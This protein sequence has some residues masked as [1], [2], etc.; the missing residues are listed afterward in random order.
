MTLCE[1]L[2]KIDHTAPRCCNTCRNAGTHRNCDGCLSRTAP[3]EPY[4]YRNWEPGNWLRDLH[5]AELRGECAIVIGGQ[6]EADFYATSS[7][8]RVAKHLHRVACS[9][10][11]LCG[12]LTGSQ[13][14]DQR[15]TIHT[16]EGGYI[17]HWHGGK[18]VKL[19]TEDGREC[20]NKDDPG[21]REW[22]W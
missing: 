5:A 10:G 13:D 22:F 21:L 11:Y 17:V 12:R 4:P 7:P 19:T 2:D 1:L 3:G 8:E 6:G 20:W 14:G 9:C 15:L 16:A 18:L